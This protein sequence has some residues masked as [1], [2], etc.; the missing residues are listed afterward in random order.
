[1][2]NII[3]FGASRE[4]GLGFSIGLPDPD[5]TVFLISRTRPS[6]L[7]CSN[8]VSRVWIAGFIGLGD[9]GKSS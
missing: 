5:H 6:S 4:I 7:D 2:A 8:Q 1:M 3:F 9:G